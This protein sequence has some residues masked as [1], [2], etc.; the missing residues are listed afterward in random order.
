VYTGINVICAARVLV[1]ISTQESHKDKACA[2]SGID[3][4][5]LIT[6]CILRHWWALFAMLRNNEREYKEEK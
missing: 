3:G 1:D 2:L 5:G 4:E 6:G